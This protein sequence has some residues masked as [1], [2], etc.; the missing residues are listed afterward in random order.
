MLLSDASLVLAQVLA[1][2]VEGLFGHFK[3]C[4]GVFER[5]VEVQ[6]VGKFEWKSTLEWWRIQCL[7][8]VL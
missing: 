8:A 3:G 7:M 4:V 6:R 1:S 5:V 2:S